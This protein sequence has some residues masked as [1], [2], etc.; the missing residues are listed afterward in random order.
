M[1]AKVAECDAKTRFGLPPIAEFDEANCQGD[2]VMD[3]S[4]ID[5]DHK[6]VESSGGEDEEEEEILKHLKKKDGVMHVMDNLPKRLY[7]LRN[8]WEYLEN[9]LNVFRRVGHQVFHCNH[10]FLW[11]ARLD[12]TFKLFSIP[13]CQ[14]IFVGTLLILHASLDL[15]CP[16][17]ALVKDV[18]S[19]AGWTLNRFLFLIIHEAFMVF[20]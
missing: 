9:N 13:L 11:F 1:S 14:S 8:L 15:F 17:W 6:D 10:T 18:V 7:V 16:H 19:S 20:R 2:N 3:V 5:E 12:W 4:P